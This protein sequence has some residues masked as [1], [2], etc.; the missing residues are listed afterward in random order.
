MLTIS[1]LAGLEGGSPYMIEMNRTDF[2]TNIAAEFAIYKK[3]TATKSRIRNATNN[4]NISE[5]ISGSKRKFL[6]VEEANSLSFLKLQQ[7]T[8]RFF[9]KFT[10]PYNIVNVNHR[11]GSMGSFYTR[12]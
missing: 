4:I 5:M 10:L 1:T 9:F 3:A 11:A 8:L 12:N 6:F 7:A 2:S